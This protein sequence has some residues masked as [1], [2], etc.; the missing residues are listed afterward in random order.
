MHPIIRILQNLL[1]KRKTGNI[2]F[3]GLIS[4]GQTDIPITTRINLQ[5]GKIKSVN[6][7]ETIEIPDQD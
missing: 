1:D 3:K 5:K 2:S 4:I 6:L 7:E